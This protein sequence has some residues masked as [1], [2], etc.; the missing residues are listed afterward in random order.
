[1][2]DIYTLGHHCEE[3]VVRVEGRPQPGQKGI[4][5]RRAMS[6]CCG[7]SRMS[8]NFENDAS[9]VRV[10][11]STTRIPLDEALFFANFL[12]ANSPL[13]QETG[14]IHNG[15]VGCAGEVRYTCYD[16]GRHNVLDKILGRAHLQNL[17]LAD[18]VL[19]F[20]GRVSSEIL[21]KVAKMQIPILVARSAPTDL[22]LALAEDL[23]ITVAGFAR[24]DRVNIYTCP[25]R[26]KLPPLIARNMPA[27]VNS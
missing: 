12:D 2:S 27:A 5:T 23:N 4:M 9:L 16:I 11:D 22:A 26:I 25:E 6:S 21:L 18:H 17:D 14:G 20:S 24:G 1:M 13:F 10:Q 3:N 7:K 19:F 8:F 15:G